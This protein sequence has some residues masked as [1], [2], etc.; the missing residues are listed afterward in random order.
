VLISEI[1][2]K[3]PPL[4][5][6]FVCIYLTAR[7]Q[8]ILPSNRELVRTETDRQIDRE[9]GTEGD[10][11]KLCS[12]GKSSRSTAD[13]CNLFA[14][15]VLW[16]VCSHKT[17]TPCIVYDGILNVLDGD[18]R[19]IDSQYTRTLQTHMHTLHSNHNSVFVRHDN[20]S[21]ISSAHTS[22]HFNFNTALDTIHCYHSQ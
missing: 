9:G 19:F 22:S 1:S 3:F 15:V 8:E 14:S 7:L 11:V 4:F 21:F 17:M 6:V 18:G 16:Q 2:S 13:D 20:I 12:A 5:S 10:L